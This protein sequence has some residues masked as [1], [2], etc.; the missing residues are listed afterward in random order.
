MLGFE[1]LGELVKLRV[2]DEAASFKLANVTLSRGV[3]ENFDLPNIVLYL[4]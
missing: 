4:P 2:I 1:V 3:P